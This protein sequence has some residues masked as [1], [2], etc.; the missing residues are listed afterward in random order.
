MHLGPGVAG[1]D[2]STDVFRSVSRPPVSVKVDNASPIPILTSPLTRLVPPD[3][4]KSPKVIVMEGVIKV[5]PP[6]VKLPVRIS[7]PGKMSPA[8]SVP[9]LVCQPPHCWKLLNQ[10][11][12]VPETQSTPLDKM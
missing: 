9:A 7:Q 5:P 3:C 12:T 6:R 1:L 4:V 2:A 10:A 11:R 8:T